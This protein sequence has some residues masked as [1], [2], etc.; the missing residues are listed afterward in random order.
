V[1]VIAVLSAPQLAAASAA[2]RLVLESLLS[3]EMLLSA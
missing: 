1:H 3:E 2:L